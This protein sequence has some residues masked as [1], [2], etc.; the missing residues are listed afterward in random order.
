M[1]VGP[2]VPRGLY[3]MNQ[4][5]YSLDLFI[6]VHYPQMPTAIPPPPNSTTEGAME[7]PSGRGFLGDLLASEYF[8][9]DH[10]NWLREAGYTLRPRYNPEWVPSWHGLKNPLPVV[11]YEDAQTRYVSVKLTFTFD[12]PLLTHRLFDRRRRSWTHSVCLME[13]SLH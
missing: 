5:S 8:W 12:I 1:L 3:G 11:Y 2:C 4:I 10:Y 7:A 6:L 13:L 9:R